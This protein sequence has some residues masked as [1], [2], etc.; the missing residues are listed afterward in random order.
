[1]NPSQKRRRDIFSFQLK[2]PF[3]LLLAPVLLLGSTALAVQSPALASSDSAAGE[4]VIAPN[5]VSFTLDNGL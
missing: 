5:L 4:L 2:R 1:M 3:G